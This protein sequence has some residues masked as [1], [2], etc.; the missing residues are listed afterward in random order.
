MDRDLILVLEEN[1]KDKI[2]KF[3]VKNS[4]G[5]KYKYKESINDNGIRFIRIELFL[6]D[7]RIYFSYDMNVILGFID[8]LDY[9]LN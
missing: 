2:K 8:G 1:L 6:Y 9:M 4:F 7:D 5:L 3:N